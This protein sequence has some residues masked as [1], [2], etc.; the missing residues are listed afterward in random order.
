MIYSL[1]SNDNLSIFTSKNKVNPI[2][3]QSGI[4]TLLTVFKKR[5]CMGQC[6]FI[7]YTVSNAILGPNNFI[8]VINIKF[9]TYK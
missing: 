7:D 4:S 1:I 6:L 3:K 9:H 5:V 8:L 2:Y